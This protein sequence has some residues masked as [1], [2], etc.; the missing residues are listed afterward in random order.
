M[1]AHSFL[2]ASLRVVKWL[3]LPFFV[4]ARNTELYSLYAT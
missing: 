3:P 4:H 2:F 1:T